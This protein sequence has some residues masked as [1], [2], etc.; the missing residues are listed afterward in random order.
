MLAQPKSIASP[1]SP[2]PCWWVA[3]KLRSN[4][5]YGGAGPRRH[6]PRR[7][8]GG[9]RIL[10]PRWPRRAGKRSACC[11]T[12][13]ATG[14]ATARCWKSTF[15]IPPIATCSNKTT[16]WFPVNI[17]RYDENLDIAAR[18]GVPVD[19]GVPALAVLEPNGQ[20]VYSQR[21]GEFEAM[22]KMDS[23]S[24]T[25]FLLQWKGSIPIAVEGLVPS[26]A[27][28]AL[29]KF[30]LALLA[31]RSRTTYSAPPKGAAY[32]AI[33]CLFPTILVLTTLLAL[34]P[35]SDTLRGEMR[36]AF[37]EV[38]PR[39]HHDPAA[40]LLHQPEGPL[41]TGGLLRHPG[42]PGRRHGHDALADGRLSPRLRAAPPGMELLGRAR[43]A[44][45]LVPCAW[46]P[47]LL[48]P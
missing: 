42:Q 2:A 31:L 37:A 40:R 15:T 29:E 13:A 20:V 28:R 6:L 32:S 41:R 25:A 10:R 8:P 16:C 7:R 22:R 23:A 44:L 1:L 17:G 9:G 3:G 18:Y 47:W 39:R 12:S 5:G 19:K 11:S 14:A 21:N 43:V 38:L 30:R 24:V 26:M 27:W 35:E 48:P 45:A 46:C 33:L 34:T 4:R 36:A